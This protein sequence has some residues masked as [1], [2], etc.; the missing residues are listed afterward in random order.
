MT[1]ETTISKLTGLPNF[2]AFKE[3]KGSS[4]V[5]MLDVNGLRMFNEDFSYFA[6]DNLIQRVG[7]MLVYVEL[8]AYHFAGGRFLCKGDSREELSAKLVQAQQLLKQRRID[9][10]FGIGANLGEAE[11]G[12]Y[13]QKRE[14]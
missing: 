2:R 9:F 5:A 3:E 14:R 7:E 13:R 6:G 4:F 8:A 1:D 10:C 11:A 12:L